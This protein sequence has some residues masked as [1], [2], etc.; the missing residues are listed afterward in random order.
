V[1]DFSDQSLKCVLWIV[2]TF[3]ILLDAWVLRHR[4][5]A[6]LR[7]SDSLSAI[8]VAGVPH[9][10]PETSWR[11]I[12]Q[13]IEGEAVKSDHFSEAV[14]SVGDVVEGVAE[15]GPFRH[16]RLAKPRQVRDHMK[17]VGELRNEIAEHGLAAAEGVQE[18]SND[19]LAC[20][21]LN[22]ARRKGSLS[23]SETSATN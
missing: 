16:V 12:V 10:K 8:E 20:Q 23:Q 6:S 15:L 13:E 9:R 22:E 7:D 18:R 4:G 5:C 2:R 1:A 11:C 3:T 14:N 19:R 17:S 21:H